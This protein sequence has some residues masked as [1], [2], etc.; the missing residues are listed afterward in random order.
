MLQNEWIYADYKR[1]IRAYPKQT[2]TLSKRL[3]QANAYTKQTL[4]L[5]KTLSQ[6]FRTFVANECADK[7]RIPSIPMISNRPPFRMYSS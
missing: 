1:V 3:H 5:S 6:L 7:D 2:L 4:T